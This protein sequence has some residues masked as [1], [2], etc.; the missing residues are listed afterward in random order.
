MAFFVD[1]AL[2][3]ERLT[4]CCGTVRCDTVRYGTVRYGTLENSDK[5]GLPTVGKFNPN[6]IF[7]E[8]FT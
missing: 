1:F 7:L 3:S 8:E 2:F 5:N 6:L 4:V